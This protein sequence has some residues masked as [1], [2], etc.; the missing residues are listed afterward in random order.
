[1]ERRKKS[2]TD[3]LILRFSALGDIAMT[4][5]VVRSYAQA[6][7][8]LSF[9]MASAPMLEPLFA[10]IPNLKFEGIDTKE[11]NGVFGIFRLYRRLHRFRPKQLLDLHQVLRTYLLCA[12]FFLSGTTSIFGVKKGRRQ[13]FH[14]TK[15]KDKRLQP[16]PSMIS[17]YTDVFVRSGF[18]PFPIHHIP[19]NKRGA[20]TLL[21]LYPSAKG[22]QDVTKLEHEKWL[23]IAPF[24]KHPTKEWPVERMERVVDQMGTSGKY[25]I[26]LFGG[27][28]LERVILKNWE[29]RYPNTVCVAGTLD[30]AHELTLMGKMDLFISMD[31]ANMHFASFM[32][33]PVLS[34]WGGTHPYAGFYGWRQDPNLAI[35]SQIE[36]RPCSVFGSKPCRWGT[37]ACLQEIS[38]EE[39]LHRIVQFFADELH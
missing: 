18:L 34:I 38:V 21:D 24:A 12:L 39:V 22:E 2:I 3:V 11:Y 23:G 9:V 17:K 20:S 31:S 37:I 36:C 4:A 32:G 16:I 19:L 26:F 25:R 14:L 27:G 8:N 1:M 13:R 28:K 33:V 5:P 15:V 7:P 6:Y 35:Q 10:G 29:L 30:F